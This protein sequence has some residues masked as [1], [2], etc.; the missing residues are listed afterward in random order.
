MVK[1]IGIFIAVLL[2]VMGGILGLCSARS[3]SLSADQ[4]LRIHIRA[5]SNAIEDQTVKYQVKD[6]IVSYL[7]PVLAEAHTKQQAMTLIS[8]NLG[9]LSEIARLTLSKAGYN[10]GANA[11]LRSETFP[12]RCYDDVVLEGGE[13]DSLIIELGSAQGDNWWCVVYPPL[14]F[15]N[16]E[17]NDTQNIVYRSKLVEI[18]KSF[19]GG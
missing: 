14:C 3:T 4:F 11:I 8:Q 15:V 1:Q 6:A 16:A 13:Y 5:N 17:N 9:N 12:T 19:F 7:T 18:I 2:V 10:Y